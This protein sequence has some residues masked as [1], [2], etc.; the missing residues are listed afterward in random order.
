MR[1]PAGSA[2][3][4]WHRF[5]MRIE[6]LAAFQNAAVDFYRASIESNEDEPYHS[7]SVTHRQRHLWECTRVDIVNYSL[8]KWLSTVIGCSVDRIRQSRFDVSNC[9]EMKQY[10]SFGFQFEAPG[11]IVSSHYSSSW[12]KRLSPL[13]C[14]ALRLSALQ[15]NEMNHTCQSRFTRGRPCLFISISGIC[16]T[17][18]DGARSLPLSLLLVLATVQLAGRAT[19]AHTANR[20]KQTHEQ[21]KIFFCQLFW[22]FSTELHTFP[23][24]SR[25]LRTKTNQ[26]G[27]LML[28]FC[29]KENRCT[30]MGKK[31]ASTVKLP[32]EQYRKQIGKQ[33]NK[34][35]KPALR[36]TRL[37]AEAKRSAPG[38]RQFS[39]LRTDEDSVIDLAQVVLVCIVIFSRL[40]CFGRFDHPSLNPLK[41]TTLSFYIVLSRIL[42]PSASSVCAHAPESSSKQ[43]FGLSPCMCGRPW[44]VG[45]LRS[46][47]SS[48]RR[49]VGLLGCWGGCGRLA[50]CCGYRRLPGARLS[51]WHHLARSRDAGGLSC[52]H[53][54]PGKMDVLLIIVTVLILLLVI[55][56]LFY[57]NLSTELNLDSDMD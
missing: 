2:A 9:A 38:I 10:H 20:Y 24:E 22:E 29:G 4:G 23:P 57:L 34:K 41:Q 54:W 36:A 18:V 32:V 37:R 25:S 17:A 52:V 55:Y 49:P 5:N 3:L 28:D 48:T 19:N 35:A 45:S 7:S 42:V 12:L 44:Q 30:R 13:C 53:G 39:S 33:D 51:G 8:S 21:I 14:R 31:D 43:R 11:D 40:V 47:L 56:A 15:L 16:D 6:S 26:V 46:L 27:G 50:T 1:D